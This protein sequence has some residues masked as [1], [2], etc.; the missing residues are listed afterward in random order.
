VT[1][2]EDDRKTPEVQD[3]SRQG[4]CRLCLLKGCERPFHPPHPLSRYCSA[5][6]EAAARRWRQ[7]TANRAYRSSPQGKE[8]RREQSRRYRMRVRQRK[9]AENAPREGCEGY[10]YGPA[11]NF[12]CRRP[13]CYEHVQRTARSPR[14]RFCSSSCHNALRR[15]QIRERRWRRW[16]GLPT[17]ARCQRDDFW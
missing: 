8:R 9:A 13:G 6:C 5:E 10:S 11:G 12:F 4:R 2:R 15:V 17:L 14:Q 16:L 7:R 1:Q 3:G